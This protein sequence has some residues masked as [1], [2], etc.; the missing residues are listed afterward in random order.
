MII[1]DSGIE[2]FGGA[3]NGFNFEIEYL[4]KAGC[5]REAVFAVHPDYTLTMAIVITSDR[6]AILWAVKDGEFYPL[7]I[8]FPHG[9]RE[10]VDFRRPAQLDGQSI[11]HQLIDEM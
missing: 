8:R 1:T 4:D 2:L 9:L 5:Y 10:L 11:L 7:Y 6:E 3:I